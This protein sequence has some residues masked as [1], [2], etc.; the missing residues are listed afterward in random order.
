MQNFHI[1]QGRSE[2]VV[3]AKV[4]TSS[5]LVCP[6]G[7]HHFSSIFGVQNWYLN[8]TEQNLAQIVKIRGRGT[9]L[10]VARHYRLWK[11]LLENYKKVFRV[12]LCLPTQRLVQMQKAQKSYFSYH[13][14]T[15]YR[16]TTNEN[17]CVC[18]N[19]YFE[20]ISCCCLLA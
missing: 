20:I 1:T 2:L 17:H 5:C 12:S 14:H 19:F 16:V 8:V 10:H 9:L 13:R 6:V 18:C 3:T 11:Q 15:V 4:A 7:S